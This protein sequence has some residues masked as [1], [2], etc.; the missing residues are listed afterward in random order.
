MS[1][2]SR[3]ITYMVDQLDLDQDLCYLCMINVLTQ[4]EEAQTGMQKD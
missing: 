2:Y 1:N 4:E 3:R